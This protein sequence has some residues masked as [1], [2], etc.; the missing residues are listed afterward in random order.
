M[1]THSGVVHATDVRRECAA[2]YGSSF[3]P[4]TGKVAAPS[5][6]SSRPAKG[7]VTRDPNFKTCVVRATNHTVDAGKTFTRNYYSRRQ[8]FNAD[9]TRFMVFANDN[10]WHLYDANT[11]TRL[12]TL[13]GLSSDSEPHWDPSDPRVLYYSRDTRLLKLDA[14][15]NLTTEATNFGGRLPWRNASKVWTQREGS[16][17]ANGRYWC[18]LAEEPGGGVLGVFTYD[19]AAQRILGTRTLSS[20]PDHV[21]MSPSGRHCV[22]AGGDV[23]GATV[24]WNSAFS[25]SR[26]LFSKSAHSD[27]ALGADGSDNFIFVDYDN[28]GNLTVVNLDTGK[29][30]ALWSVYVK[31]T[32]T[33]MHISGKNFARPGWFLLSTFNLRKGKEQWLHERVMA[34]EMKANPTIVNLAH[35]HSVYNGYWT[36]PHASVSRDFRRV[37]F[38]SN[39]GTSSPRDVDSFMIVLPDD[40]LTRGYSSRDD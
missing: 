20:K 35:H 18:F 11:L 7:A 2:I 33:S 39:W 31:G 16:P 32:A 17:S 14:E 22:V 25:T 28:N 37:L 8:A 40:M 13:R 5:R 23:S 15:T 21:S 3:V 19:L 10:S 24:A 29:K 4:V 27:L 34:V 38:S 9:N 26:P 30:T 6:P 12:K 1:W 36:Q